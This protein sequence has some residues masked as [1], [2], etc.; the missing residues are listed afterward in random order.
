MF[1]LTLDIPP[2]VVVFRRTNREGGIARLPGEWFVFWVLMNP[3]R[4]VRFDN[5]NRLW[6]RHGRSQVRKDVNVII[7]AADNNRLAIGFMND[8]ADVGMESE[9]KVFVDD[10]LAV[11]CAEDNVV[12]KV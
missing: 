5:P 11:L 7:D 3:F 10:W 1:L 6:D 12:D 8:A 2:K 9:A 4:R